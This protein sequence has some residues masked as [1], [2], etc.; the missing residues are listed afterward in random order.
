MCRGNK[1]L[2]NIADIKTLIIFILIADIV[3]GVIY[4]SK[5]NIVGIFNCV[6][7]AVVSGFILMN[8]G[9]IFSK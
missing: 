2:N 9:K 6:S 3:G 7:W 4:A 8:L 1:A 5:G